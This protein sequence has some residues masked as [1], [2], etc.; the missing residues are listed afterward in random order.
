KGEDFTVSGLGTFSMEG[1]D[2]AFLAEE[3]LSTEVNYKYAGM[4][5]IELIGAYKETP[6]IAIDSS[7]AKEPDSEPVPGV[8]QYTE[9]M[10][11]AAE[12]EQVNITEA[13]GQEEENG[14][15]ELPEKQAKV[16]EDI[17]PETAETPQEP[18]E[19][20]KKPDEAAK[21][22]PAVKA[23]SKKD[24]RSK[25]K[26]ES[27]DSLRKLLVAAVVIIAIGISGWMFYDLGYLG[28]SAG[29]ESGNSVSESSVGQKFSTVPEQQANNGS[30]K[31]AADTVTNKETTGTDKTSEQDES[32]STSSITGIAEASRQSVYGLRGGASPRVEDGYTIVVHSLRDE[33]KVRRLNEELQ[34]AGYRTVIS[35]ATVMDTTFWRLGLG[36]FKTIDDAKKASQSLP[37]PYKSNH[38]IKRIQ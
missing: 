23:S 11:A 5:P 38:F 6:Q 22:K 32:N 29:N 21:A 3:K 15:E 25:R 28:G 20:Q 24:F 14:K 35:G 13:A 36:Q 30:N 34:Q 31:T 26:K 37:D 1:D 18:A 9:E 12:E 7:P 4:K 8:E 17:K 27:T 33:N 19:E 10:D 16:P 2:I